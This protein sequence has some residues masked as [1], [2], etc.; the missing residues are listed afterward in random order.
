MTYHF[1][2]SHFSPLSC[3]SHQKMYKFQENFS[4]VENSLS[5]VINLSAA[6]RIITSRL[7]HGTTV[8][9][10]DETR[11]IYREVDIILYLCLS[12]GCFS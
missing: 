3:K 4:R 1:V 12:F 8:E 11:A 7:F 9:E 2:K 6:S 10:F 5:I